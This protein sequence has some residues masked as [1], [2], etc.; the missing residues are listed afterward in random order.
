MNGEILNNIWS[1]LSEDNLVDVDFDTWQK[2]FVE[3]PEVANNVY[4]YLVQ[5]NCAF[6]KSPTFVK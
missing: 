4:N 5:K 3:D 6:L 2:N 1:K